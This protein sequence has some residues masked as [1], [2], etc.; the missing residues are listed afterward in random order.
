MQEED[1]QLM[2]TERHCPLQMFPCAFF[3][4][5][6]TTQFH[7]LYPNTTNTPNTTTDLRMVL[8]DNPGTLP[9]SIKVAERRRL[10][11]SILKGQLSVLECDYQPSRFSGR[12][13]HQSPYL[14]SSHPEFLGPVDRRSFSSSSTHRTAGFRR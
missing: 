9:A 2:S 11:R 12:Q 3:D 4:T 14:H 1:R 5:L 6:A 8:Q 7:I 10:G 13:L